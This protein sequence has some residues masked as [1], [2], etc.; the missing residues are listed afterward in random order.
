MCLKHKIKQV[1]IPLNGLEVSVYDCLV[2]KK[3]DW[4]D[5]VPIKCMG[6]RLI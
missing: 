2:R 4:L 6:E 1:I 3:L 5:I